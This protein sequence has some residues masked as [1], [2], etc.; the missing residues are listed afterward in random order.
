M[1]RYINVDIDIK[2]NVRGSIVYNRQKMWIICM[3]SL[4]WNTMQI[5][6]KTWKGI[7]LGELKASHRKIL[8]CDILCS[9]QALHRHTFLSMQMHGE[10]T[11]KAI[12][13]S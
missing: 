3:I 10:K 5:F 12:P 1:Q 4:P 9:C 7:S 11:G 8:K 13:N 2:Y 6:P